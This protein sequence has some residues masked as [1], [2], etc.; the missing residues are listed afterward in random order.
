MRL[1]ALVAKNVIAYTHKKSLHF[2]NNK[3]ARKP[4]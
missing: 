3:Y 4:T 1:G 2:T